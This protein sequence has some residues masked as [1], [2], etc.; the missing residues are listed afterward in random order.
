MAPTPR[1]GILKWYKFFDSYLVDVALDHK[2]T[3][4][5]I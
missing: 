1:P 2:V 3:E 5:M 4:L